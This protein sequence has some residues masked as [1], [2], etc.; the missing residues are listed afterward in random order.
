MSFAN[1][2]QKPI[3]ILAT[4]KTGNLWIKYVLVNVLA[5]RSQQFF[6]QQ[7]IVEYFSK[8]E[9]NRQIV[10]HA[11][12]PHTNSLAEALRSNDI[13]TISLVRNPLDVFL[14]LR[15]H[16]ARLGAD[17]PL[18]AQ[19]LSKDP[20][21]LREFARSHFLG[22]LAISAIWARRGAVL[23][24]YEDLLA[25]P[26]SGFADLGRRLGVAEAEIRRFATFCTR[27]SDIT[28]MRSNARPGDQ[29]HFTSAEIDKWK[30]P[31]NREV[32]SALLQSSSIRAAMRLW[33]YR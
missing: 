6:H 4:P 15:S 18:Q 8:P 29:E 25:D 12:V 10:F 16:V 7:D 31:E 5:M 14:S 9:A 22:D 26:L 13:K 23:V 20:D 28:E 27:L 1:L 30:R 32:I 21:R 24:R 3:A 19:I 2:A 11:H 33:G 17:S